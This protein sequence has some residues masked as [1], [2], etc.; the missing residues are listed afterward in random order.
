MTASRLVVLV[1][2]VEA[3]LL[4]IT[5]A[6]ILARALWSRRDE[7]VREEHL[8]PARRLIT[9]NLDGEQSLGDDIAILRELSRAE[10]VR[11][12]F[13]VAGN[14]GV[15]ER[16]WLRSLA[17]VI[18]LQDYAVRLTESHDWW[19]RLSGARLLTL[20]DAEPEMILPLLRD[21][22][23][24]V[25]VQ[26]TQYIAQHPTPEGID[27]LMRLLSSNDP[28]ARFA[29]KDALMRLGAEAAP[30]II[31]RLRNPQDPQMLPMMEIAAVTATHA[32]MDAAAA[33]LDNPD[34]RV[35]RLVAKLLRN[36]GGPVAAD[37]HVRILRDPAERLRE[38]V[39]E[40]IGFLNH[41]TASPAVAKLLDDPA[42]RVRLA[43]ARALDC[44]GP[45]GELLLRRAKLKGSENASAAAR[46]ILDDPSRSPVVITTT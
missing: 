40:A 18:G 45:T 9:R 37:Y 10:Q 28:A 17:R 8:L 27:A 14:V 12:Y 35:R 43:A 11:L 44:L 22:R 33:N 5:V 39:V 20:L 21:E 23:S 25:R 32:Y 1:L 2:E 16:A 34:P 42:S 7:R 15:G 3:A 4:V 38:V 41:W 24:A 46:R 29:A 19:K 13:D 36:V 26:V 31:S 30:T 6:A